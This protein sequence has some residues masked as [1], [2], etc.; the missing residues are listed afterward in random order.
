MSNIFIYGSCVSRDSYNLVKERHSLSGY[1]ARQSFI[2]ATSKP[3]SLLPGSD[4]ESQFQNRMLTGDLKSNALAV[5][6][7][8]ASEIDLL[9]IDLT[10]E[11]LGVHKLPDG[12]FV[13]RSTELVS[14][15]RLLSLETPPG[16]IRFGT[17][18]HEIFWKRSASI[19]MRRLSE[20]NLL[21]K[22]LIMNTPWAFETL[23]SP[24][25]SAESIQEAKNARYWLS[26]YAQHCQSLGAA[27]VNLPE[28][29][30]LATSDHRWGLARYHYSNDAYKWMVDQW[31]YRLAK[32]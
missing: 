23:D 30:A 5:M 15:R 24:R 13:T 22:T 16:L 17:E 26:R 21:R 7:S 10:D 31:D 29:L 27:V 28:E 3:T 19:M 25:F 32:M 9:V 18:R 4:M 14:S 20:M 6:R 12:S 2:S 8:K 11:R 1:V